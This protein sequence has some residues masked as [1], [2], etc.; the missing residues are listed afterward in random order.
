[1]RDQTSSAASKWNNKKQTQPR[2]SLQFGGTTNSGKLDKG[3]AF[4]PEGIF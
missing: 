4:V 3:T 1:M 2:G